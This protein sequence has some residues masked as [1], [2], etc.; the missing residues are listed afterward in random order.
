MPNKLKEKLRNRTVSYGIW[1]EW[2]DPDII[3]FCGYLG[4]DYVMIEAEHAP[5]DRSTAT[6]LMRAADL[7]GM[8]P[9]VRVPANDPAVILGYLEIGTK[10]IYVPHV[11]TREDAERIVRSVKF[12]PEGRRGGGSWRAVQYGLKD[13]PEQFFRRANEETMVIALV[14]ET[15]GIKNLDAILDVD[16]VDVVGI[17]D[18]DLSLSMGYVGQRGHP[19]VRRIVDEAESKIAASSKAL[20]AVIGD[21]DEARAARGRGCTMISLKVSNALEGTFR[22][23]LAEMGDGSA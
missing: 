12:P 9:I 6:E 8:V 2:K 1:L 17:G 21:I 11:N 4:F 3:E 19:D 20:D 14:E 5:L 10:G 13:S 22:R 18:G 23:F 15:E 16:G 7:V